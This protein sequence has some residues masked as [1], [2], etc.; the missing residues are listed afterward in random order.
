MTTSG[1]PDLMRLANNLQSDQKAAQETDEAVARFGELMRQRLQDGDTPVRK[2]WLSS[3]VDRIEVDE[4][5]I[6]LFGRKDILEQCVIS[7]APGNPG[8][9][10]FVP[11]W[12]TRQDSNL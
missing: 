7:G 1:K 12:R 8:V 3:I 10:T 5:K 9:R 6:R 2:T 4:R 11:E